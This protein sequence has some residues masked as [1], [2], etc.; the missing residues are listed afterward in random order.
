MMALG[1]KRVAV[2]P[3]LTADP[4]DLSARR[5]R[6]TVLDVADI[7]FFDPASTGW[8]RVLDGMKAGGVLHDRSRRTAVRG[9]R[10]PLAA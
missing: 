1:P 8:S 5:Q 10:R 9:V 3:D 6:Y 7:V 4:V 2:P